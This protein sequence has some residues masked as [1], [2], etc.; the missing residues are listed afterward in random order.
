MP[1][2]VGLGMPIESPPDMLPPLI[3]PVLPVP[4]PAD[5]FEAPLPP[6]PLIAQVTATSNAPPPWPVVT[7]EVTEYTTLPRP[8]AIENTLHVEPRYPLLD[9]LSLFAGLDGHKEPADLG[10]NANFG[11]RLAAN[12]GLPVSEERGIGIQLGVGFNY[13]RSALRVLHF[14]DGTV[15]HSQVFTTAGIFRRGPTGLNWGIVYDYRFDDYYDRIDSAQWRGQFGIPVGLDNE[16]GFWGTLRDR[17][18]QAALGP[19]PVTV[20]PLNQINF[21]WRHVWP[22]EAATRV[23]LGFTEDHGRF[24]LFFRG[25]PNVR[26]PIC[27]GADFHVPLNESLAIF[28]EAQFITP[29]DS[30]TVT[31]TLG[32]AWYPGAAR[33]AARNR[34]NPYLPV[35]NNTTMPL[36]LRR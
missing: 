6:P 25:E 16:F 30:G 4:A 1:R 27:F 22:G 26:H 20:R 9:N 8:Q 19:L 14:L 28:G 32:L 17:S 36:D 13:S 10:V 35:A 12:W 34:F 15:D 33:L 31:A 23:W 3:A 29:N 5:V 11:Y 7:G 24:S 18:A 2:R 21:Y